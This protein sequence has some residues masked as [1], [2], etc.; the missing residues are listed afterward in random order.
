[1]I[2]HRVSFEVALDRSMHVV[3]SCEHASPRPAIHVQC[4]HMIVPHFSA[5]TQDFNGGAV[6]DCECLT[7]AVMIIFP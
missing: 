5:A 6:T 4:E 1:M 3:A 7:F 2:H